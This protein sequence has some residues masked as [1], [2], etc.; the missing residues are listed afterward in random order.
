MLTYS[1]FKI[2]CVE[3][4]LDDIDDDEDNEDYNGDKRT[5]SES[6]VIKIG[7]NGKTASQPI[8][9]NIDTKN[10]INDLTTTASPSRYNIVDNNNNGL[11]TISAKLNNNENRYSRAESIFDGTNTNQSNLHSYNKRMKAYEQRNIYVANNALSD[12]TRNDS[13]KSYIHIE[14]Y[15]G[16][17]DDLSTIK[18][19]NMI[20][21]SKMAINP[22]KLPSNST[23]GIMKISTTKP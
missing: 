23:D 10:P 2:F 14:V 5:A 4:H 9:G 21:P 22:V 16:N 12:S 15:K 11:P 17:L 20:S 8:Y 18:P 1:V 7:S 6:I 13:F 19:K 3:I